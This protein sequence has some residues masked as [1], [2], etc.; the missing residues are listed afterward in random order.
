MKIISEGELSADLVKMVA[1]LKNVQATD[2][3][4]VWA[5]GKSGVK[6]WGC[7]NVIGLEI[8]IQKIYSEY[9]CFLHFCI[10]FPENL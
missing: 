6:W 4:Q 8:K 7:V 10:I 9:E 2:T 3:E 1:V 5:E